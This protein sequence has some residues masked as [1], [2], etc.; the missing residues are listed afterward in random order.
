[1]QVCEGNRK[2][3]VGSPPEVSMKEGALPCL[4]GPDSQLSTPSSRTRLTG[5]GMEMSLEHTQEQEQESSQSQ[6]KIR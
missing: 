6:E 4:A 2:G 3:L 5:C 1:M